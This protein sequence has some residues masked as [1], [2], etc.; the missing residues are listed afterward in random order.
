MV[1]LFVFVLFYLISP[2]HFS[3]VCHSASKMFCF[4]IGKKFLKTVSLAFLWFSVLVLIFKET[5]DQFIQKSQ[6]NE[7]LSQRIDWHDYDFIDYERTRTGPGERSGYSL[8]D[9]IE[10]AKSEESIKTVGVSLIVSEKVS[11]TRALKDPRDKK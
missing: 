6:L 1:T 5:S 4:Q 10:I 7:S 2:E 9:P 8:T 3:V 11:L